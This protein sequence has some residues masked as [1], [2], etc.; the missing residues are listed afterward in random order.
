MEDEVRP[1]H[2]HSQNG[3]QCVTTVPVCES[4]RLAAS[5]LH[6]A[7]PTHGL[8]EINVIENALSVG[9]RDIV[10]AFFAEQLDLAERGGAHTI[11]GTLVRGS[12]DSPIQCVR[13]PCDQ[14]H[15]QRLVEPFIDQQTDIDGNQQD[16][17]NGDS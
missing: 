8:K 17:K 9:K 13:D 7:T 16:S 1:S 3:N 6:Y 12:R 5:G 15:N 4:T 11:T 10:R 14:Q 2:R